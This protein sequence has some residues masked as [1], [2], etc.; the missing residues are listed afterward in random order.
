[1]GRMVKNA[2]DSTASPYHSM[3]RTGRSMRAH[4]KTPPGTITGRRIPCTT[5]QISHYEFRIYLI[6]SST[7]Q[8]SL[9]ITSGWMQA[10]TR[11]SRSFSDAMK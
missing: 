4:T 1:M 9:P 5:N 10:L 3:Q 11:R 2:A 6:S 7:G 8:W